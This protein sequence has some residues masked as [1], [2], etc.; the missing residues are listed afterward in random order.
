MG[1]GDPCY[2]YGVFQIV[3]R[4]GDELIGKAGRTERLYRQSQ[5]DRIQVEQSNF[6]PRCRNNLRD[7]VLMPQF[8]LS[9]PSASE[10]AHAGTA[11]IFSL[12]SLAIV[13]APTLRCPSPSQTFSRRAPAR[14]R[15]G[16]RWRVAR[17]CSQCQDDNC[18]RAIR[19]SLNRNRDDHRNIADLAPMQPRLRSTAASLP[20]QVLLHSWS[21]LLEVRFNCPHGC[22]R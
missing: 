18:S 4:L 14:V 19:H 6:S 5:T 13:C 7:A 8:A 11:G 21:D 17:C 22:N 9:S 2:R 20:R 16:A 3:G 10:P 12:R 1:G 15:G